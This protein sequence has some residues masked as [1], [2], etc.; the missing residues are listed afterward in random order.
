MNAGSFLRRM[1]LLWIVIS[2][3]VV[4]G[5]GV[6]AAAESVDTYLG[7][8]PWYDRQGDTWQRVVPQ[9]QPEENVRSDSGDTSPFAFARYVVVVALVVL[10]LTLVWKIRA[11]KAPLPKLR[12]D[13]RVGAAVAALPFAIPEAGGEPEHEYESACARQDW[14]RAVIWLFAWQLRSLEMVGRIHLVQG[15]TNHQYL[16]EVAADAVVANALAA[17]ISAF[18]RSYFGRDLPTAALMHDLDAQH[19]GLLRAVKT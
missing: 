18:E 2:F 3:C 15:K 10:V 1:W 9:K 13:A 7:R 17:T 16:A 5:T 12:R 8:Q 11:G 4:A 14:A 6:L 19:K